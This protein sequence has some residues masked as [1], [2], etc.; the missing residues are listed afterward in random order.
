M[1]LIKCGSLISGKEICSLPNPEAMIRNKLRTFFFASLRAALTL[2]AAIVL[3]VFLFVMIA[4]L[5]YCAVMETAVQFGTALTDTGKTMAVAAY[6]KKYGG[7]AGQAAEI[8]VTA[9]SAAYAQSQ[10]VSQTGDTSAVKNINMLQSSFLK[11]DDMI[12]LVLSYQIRSPIGLVSL[13]GRFFLQRAR[14]RAWTGRIISEEETDENDSATEYVYVTE[15]GSVYHTDPECTYL[16]LSVHAVDAGELDSLRNNS[17]AKY[18]SCELCGGQITGGTV[19]ITN[20][21]TRYHS[22][23][24]CSGLKR[25]VRQVALDELGDMRAC[26]KCGQ[27]HG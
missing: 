15:T 25:T 18:Y 5:Q 4:A 6:L 23:L 8:A 3:P 19:Y 14:V 16:K 11:E 2:E 10:V 20:E 24:S 26:S 1:F 13:P 7:D 17:G 21:G 22:S 9:L 12:D 27:L